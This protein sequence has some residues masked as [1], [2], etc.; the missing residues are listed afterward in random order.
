[1]W[2]K[3]YIIWHPENARLSIRVSDRRSIL[4]QLHSPV[5]STG[6]VSMIEKVVLGGTR[7]G[8]FSIFSPTLKPLRHQDNLM[9]KLSHDCE[10]RDLLW[11]KHFYAA[12]RQFI[13]FKAATSSK[14]FK[15]RTPM[16]V[17]PRYDEIH[18]NRD[19]KELNRL[20]YN[21]LLK[22][23]NEMR[24]T[25][26][27]SKQY[28]ILI[29]KDTP[30]DTN[31][32]V[33]TEKNM[34]QDRAVPRKIHFKTETSEGSVIN[35]DYQARIKRGAQGALAPGPP[36]SK[37][38]PATEKKTIIT[39]FNIANVIKVRQIWLLSASWVLTM[40]DIFIIHL[41]YIFVSH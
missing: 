10:T 2:S 30:A 41:L 24:K 38:P 6:S 14:I 9:K 39:I 11:F 31:N 33:A 1:M 22:N 5:N 16:T 8:D 3:V 12:Y 35:W 19:P 37:G 13:L 29:A 18:S 17:R 36:F 4:M 23:Y 7:T 25:D 34:H 28:G 20:S 40:I 26:D 21:Q 32:R 15:G 27:C